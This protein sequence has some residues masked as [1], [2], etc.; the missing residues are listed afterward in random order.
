MDQRTTITP[1]APLTD[2]TVLLR[3]PEDRDSATVYMYGQDPDIEE[4]AWLPIP[5]PCPRDVA[6]RTVHD[7]QKGWHGRHGLTLVITMS[8]AADM[9]GVLHL[10]ADAAG[11]GEIGYGIAPQYRRQGLA[12]R[13]ITMVSA[14]AFAQLGLT[15]LEI[16]VTAPGIHG[17]ASRRAAEKAGFVYEGIRRSH[18]AATGH[19][20]ED[21]LY[22][23]AAPGAGP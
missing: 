22:V 8:P 3:L 15:R 20:Y 12:T 19:D 7:L 5:F 10:S 21:P 9:C 6:I 14:W 17:L 4:T 18:I 16:V 11:V 1:T 2:G 13:A 23:L